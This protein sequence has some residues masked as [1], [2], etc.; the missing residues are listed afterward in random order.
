M[1]TFLI[2]VLLHTYHNVFCTPTYIRLIENRK[3]KYMS[4][5][6][7]EFLKLHAY[8][9]DSKVHNYLLYNRKYSNS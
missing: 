6:R 8:H 3:L 4:N 7:V 5:R 9:K 2:F 1:V